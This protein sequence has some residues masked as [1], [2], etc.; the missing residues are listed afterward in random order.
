MDRYSERL[1]CYSKIVDRYYERLDSCNG[2]V[3]R[4]NR[5]IDRYNGL[6]DRYN[7]LVD[8][9]NGLK[10]KYCHKNCGSCKAAS[11]LIEKYKTTSLIVDG[12]AYELVS[13]NGQVRNTTPNI[14][15]RIW[16]YIDIKGL[17][18]SVLNY[19]GSL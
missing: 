3:D 9:Y 6:V 7:G 10:K 11:R 12:M 17:V 19:V 14:C 18:F 1:D 5:L 4:Y 2:L 13:S 16:A 15:L 8:R